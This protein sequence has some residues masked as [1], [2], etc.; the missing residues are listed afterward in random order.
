VPERARVRLTAIAVCAAALA[1]CGGET[2]EASGIDGVV[3]SSADPSRE[4]T[5]EAQEYPDRPPVGG[6]HWPPQA[7]G[8]LGWLRCG[9]YT[10]PVPDEFA[11]HSLEHGAV[12]LTY[13]PDATDEQVAALRELAAARPDYV[14]VSPYPG[15]EAPF[16]AT[17]WGAQLAVDDPSDSR[18]REFV[19][20]YAAGPQGGEQGA[21]CANGTT[22]EDARAAIVAANSG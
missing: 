18:L 15:Q 10:E 6:P 20:R 1:G 3:L 5:T 13:L 21:D 12:W 8:V 19:D 9:V 22:P 4:H 2:G 11:V 14:L 17:A 16:A 7:G